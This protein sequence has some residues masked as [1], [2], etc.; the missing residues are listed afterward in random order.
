MRRTSDAAL[1]VGGSR[2]VVVAIVAALATLA[3]VLG[4]QAVAQA[5]VSGDFSVSVSPPVQYLAPGGSAE[6]LVEVAATGGFADPVALTAGR[7]DGTALPA[8]LTATFT[9]ASV[10]P[11]TSSKLRIVATSSYSGGSLSLRVTGTSGSLVRTDGASASADIGLVEQCL[12]SIRG[13]VRSADPGGAPLAGVTISTTSPT[14][15]VTTDADGRYEITGLS[16]GANNAPRLAFAV[17]AA[18]NAPAL[19]KVGS[20]WASTASTDLVC[21]RTPTVD[22]Q[23][24]E[25]VPARL[26]GQVLEGE[27]GADGV[28]VQPVVPPV[29]VAGAKAT[30]TSVAQATTDAEGR[31]DFRDSMSGDL[32]IAPGDRN[33]S[34]D[35][36]VK[37]DGPITKPLRQRYW[38]AT[39][40][41]RRSKRPLR[42]WSV[43]ARRLSRD[44][45]STASLPSP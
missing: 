10:T 33:A 30:V 3:S 36:T 28:T 13:T 16:L 9:P 43:S 2:R 24:V 7:G 15:S 39:P 44:V 32:G 31:Y 26:G 45:S 27:L 6:Y 37:V 25:V 19:N 29:P 23:L 4:L 1:T 11:R 41:G 12:V 17:K 18:K 14:K 35:Y 21:G 20:Y 40:P 22:F 5:E 42:F 8:G 34:V 38:S